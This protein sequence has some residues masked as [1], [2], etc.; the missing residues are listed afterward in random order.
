LNEVLSEIYDFV[1]IGAGPTSLESLRFLAKQENSRDLRIALVSPDIFG[2]PLTQPIGVG[3]NSTSARISSDNLEKNGLLDHK[4]FSQAFFWGA[5]CLPT[6][7]HENKAKDFKQ[8]FAEINARWQV[9]AELDVMSELY[10]LRGA[11]LGRLRRKKLAN[12]VVSQIQNGKAFHVG[13]SRLAISTQGEDKCNLHGLCFISCPNNSPWNPRKLLL[14]IL[15]ETSNIVLKEEIVNRLE[16]MNSDWRVSTNQ[17]SVLI[18]KNVVLS[19]GWEQTL[20][21]L[22][23]VPALKTAASQS[24]LRGTPVSLLPVFIRKR[25]SRED[26]ERSFT[27]H[28][29]IQVE[30]KHQLFIQIYLPTHEIAKRTLLELPVLK[31]AKLRLSFQKIYNFTMG[32]HIAIAMVFSKSSSIETHEKLDSK[33]IKSLKSGLN[34]SLR[35]IGGRVINFRRKDLDPLE[36]HHVGA[37]AILRKKGQDLMYGEEHVDPLLP[38]LHVVGPTLL[39]DIEAGPHTISAAALSVI[40]LT[41]YLKNV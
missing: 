9:Q 21:I 11:T 22:K 7:D 17:G 15:S 6:L 2:I 41:R 31:R 25:T 28:D 14:E 18:A 36:S 20:K 34:L 16:Q 5:S 3:L 19:A 40:Y 33:Q 23:D 12:A 29:L 27:Y 10:S 24:S 37:L 4:H 38:G 8:V 1:F 13:H 30:P 39:P 35:P 26:F 32:R